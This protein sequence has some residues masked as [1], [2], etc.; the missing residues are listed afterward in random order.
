MCSSG[1]NGYAHPSDLNANKR[2]SLLVYSTHC[3]QPLLQYQSCHNHSSYHTMY[4]SWSIDVYINVIYLRIY[5]IP[6]YL[7]INLIFAQILS[8]C[9]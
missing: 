1:W 2:A 7:R 9:V 6:R 8:N 5:E 3:P 4:L